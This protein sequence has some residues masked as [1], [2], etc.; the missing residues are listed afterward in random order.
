[1]SGKTR[2]DQLQADLDFVAKF[3]SLTNHQATHKEIAREMGF[4]EYKSAS[5][6][7]RRVVARLGKNDQ[8]DIARPPSPDLSDEELLAERFRKFEKRDAYEKYKK[9]I[10]IRVN[11][12]LP[13]GILHF[14]DPHVDDDGTDLRRMQADVELVKRTSGLYGGNIG[15]TTNNWVGGLARLYA[16]QS[17]SAREAWVL[18]KWLITSVQWLYIIKGN[19]DC[20][21]GAGDPLDYICNES[22][23]PMV[24]AARMKLM[25]ENGAEFTIN[26]RH[27][28]P[29]HS[30]WN[31][32]HG[33]NRAAQMGFRDDLLIAG[34]KHVSGYN[35]LKCPASGVVTHCVQ[36]ASYKIHDKYANEKGL[37]DQNISPSV[38]TVLDPRATDPAGR[39]MVF[40][41]VNQGAEF[42]TYLR[43]KYANG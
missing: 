42:L 20:W 28:F 25:F 30:M 24:A 35:I 6:R 34:H 40:H 12:D 13:I 43:E 41:D 37:P 16:Q 11:T 14:G 3:E 27:Q 1:M 5:Q 19:H 32:A 29:G 4:A 15:D 7:Y 36:V 8:L 31:A 9:L 26:A 17:T 39:V 10:P 2:E 21:S 38:V 33:Q 18:A 23:S 22:V